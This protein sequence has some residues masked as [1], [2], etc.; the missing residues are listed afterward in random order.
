MA[1][2]LPESHTVN[3]AKER[4]QKA[5]FDAVAQGIADLQANQTWTVAGQSDQLRNL[6]FAYRLASGG[7]QPG[8]IEVAK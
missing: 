4:A 5:I 3:S 6:A 7:A 1:D 2:K 8:S